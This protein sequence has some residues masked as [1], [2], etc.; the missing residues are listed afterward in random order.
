VADC[1]PHSE[2]SLTKDPIITGG[3]WLCMVALDLMTPAIKAIPQKA[4]I[5]DQAQLTMFPI[6]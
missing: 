6:L 4:P 1:A 5:K 2:G 3:A